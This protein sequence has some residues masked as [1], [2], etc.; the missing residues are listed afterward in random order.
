MKIYALNI[1]CSVVQY[2]TGMFSQKLLIENLF[3]QLG[4]CPFSYLIKTWATR[5]NYD[6]I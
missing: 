5:K 4:Y 6:A 1:I 2:A 3:F